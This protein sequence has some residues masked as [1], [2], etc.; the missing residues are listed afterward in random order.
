[1]ALT[2]TSTIT[3][4]EG[5][6]VTNAYGRIAVLDEIDGTRL[7]SALRIYMNEQAFLDGKAPMGNLSFTTDATFAYDRA[8]DGND[9]LDLAHDGFIAT[10]ASEGIS[11]TKNL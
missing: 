2:I 3:T 6:E 4:P 9:I 8:T 5:F 11:A 10:L 1:M 7:I